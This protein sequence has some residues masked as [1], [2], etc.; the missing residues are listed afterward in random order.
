[1]RLLFGCEIIAV[2]VGAMAEAE[3]EA[4][5]GKRNKRVKTQDLEVFLFRF[6]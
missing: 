4:H 1:M 5:T 6:N 3:V 2:N